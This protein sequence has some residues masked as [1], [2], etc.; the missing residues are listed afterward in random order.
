[1]FITDIW[2][3][4]FR[5]PA[6]MAPLGRSSGG[7]PPSGGRRSGGGEP[8]DFD[9]QYQ[10]AFEEYV[11]SVLS[12]FLRK[13]FPREEAED[14]TQESFL[15]VYQSIGGF[16]GEAS[17]KTWIFQIATN[18]WRNEIRKRRADKRGGLE[19]SLEGEVE[20]GESIRADRPLLGWNEGSPGALEKILV[21]EGKRKLHE[22]LERLPPRMRNCVLLRIQDLKYREIADLM[23]VKI[24]TVKA[25]LSIA[26]DRLKE[27]LG[28]YFDLFDL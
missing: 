20:K 22:V 16:R 2:N 6:W 18:T 3:D 24:G 4:F 12:F 7:A 13:G 10:A 27:E 15:R 1:M 5:F 28:P 8:P 25:Q 21:D 14:L 11:E 19:I 9:E 26:Q 23:G 17:L